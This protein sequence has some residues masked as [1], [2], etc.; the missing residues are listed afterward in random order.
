[1]VTDGTFEG[2]YSALSSSLEARNYGACIDGVPGQGE[3]VTRFMDG[4]VVGIAA[5][6]DGGQKGHLIAFSEPGCRIG[7]LLIPRHYDTPR[8]FTE[9][10]KARRIGGEDE[11]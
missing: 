3:V 2:D 4:E 6:A 10:R 11:A 8:E 9:A 1:M 5:A 7:K